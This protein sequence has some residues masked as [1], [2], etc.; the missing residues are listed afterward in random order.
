MKS[1]MRS[2]MMVLCLRLGLTMRVVVSALQ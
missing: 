1:R 2:N